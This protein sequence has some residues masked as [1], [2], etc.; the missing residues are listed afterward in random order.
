M[1]LIRVLETADQ[2]DHVPL[3]MEVGIIR[4]GPGNSRDNHYYPEAMLRRDAHV[5]AGVKMYESDHR[6][7]EKSTRTWVSTV[8]EVTGFEEDGTPVGKVIVHDPDFARRILALNEAGLLS[9][10]E[11]S[12]LA[13]GTAKRGVVDGKKYRV[14]ESITEA[15]AVD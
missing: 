12:I 11:C 1:S 7:E 3:V 14:V 8:A 4:P 13:A 15:F 9:K 2:N 6:D 10:M 5:F